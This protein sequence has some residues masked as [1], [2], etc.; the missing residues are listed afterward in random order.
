MYL[1]SKLKKKKKMGKRI[2]NLN[3]QKFIH[4]QVHSKFQLVNSDESE[5]QKRILR[6]FGSQNTK[7]GFTAIRIYN[8]KSFPFVDI[9]II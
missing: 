3:V 4:L 8:A 7:N 9:F 2:K 5:T 1:S 6:N